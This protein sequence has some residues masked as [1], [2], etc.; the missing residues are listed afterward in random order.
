ME[1]LDS[2]RLTYVVSKAIQNPEIEIMYLTQQMEQIAE[3]IEYCKEAIRDDQ[4]R[5]KDAFEKGGVP[6][7]EQYPEYVD[8]EKLLYLTYAKSDE[9][10]G[11]YTESEFNIHP[12]FS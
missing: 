1:Y 6:P 9:D 8:A 2:S 5:L 7:H 11:I 12:E 3:M 10:T 4:Q